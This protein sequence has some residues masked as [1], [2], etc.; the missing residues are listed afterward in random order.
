MIILWIMIFATVQLWLYMMKSRKDL[1]DIYLFVVFF[2]FI[3]ACLWLVDTGTA[4]LYETY[5]FMDR[6]NIYSFDVQ[7]W[8]V[9]L[10]VLLSGLWLLSLSLLRD[11][12]NAISVDYLVEK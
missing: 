12:D 2:T 10:A 9:S 1:T 5:S 6:M 8:L 4:D 11:I 7:H 3:C